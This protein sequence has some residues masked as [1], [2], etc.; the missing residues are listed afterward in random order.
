[1]CIR[2]SYLS[3]YLNVNPEGTPLPPARFIM[4]SLNNLNIKP[5]DL[6]EAGFILSESLKQM[7]A[8]FGRINQIVAHSLG[9]VFLANAL[10]QADDFSTLPQHICLDRGPTSLW[11]VSKKY[12][13]GI[14]LLIYPIAKCGG[15][16]ADVEEDLLTYCS[17]AENKPALLITGVLQDHH[18]SGDANLCF[19]KKIKA[20]ENA[21]ILI[22]DPPRQLVH[23]TAHHNLRPDFLN[24]RYLLEE[25]D[26]I[27][28]S[29]NLAAAII[30]RSFKRPCLN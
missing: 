23:Q 2:D 25:S 4:I 5:A 21:E 28:H 6:D 3:A 11:E 15:W 27:Q 26:F 19:S 22:F 18:F 24:P 12:G 17:K 10:K 30:R 14:G 7:N 16:V 8:I 1:M 29:E 20:L 13:W 9:T